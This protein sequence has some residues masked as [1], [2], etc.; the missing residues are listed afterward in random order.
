MPD[1]D[2]FYWRVTQWLLPSFSLIPGRG[3]R[4]GTAW[5]PVDDEHC[6]RYSIGLSPD[7]DMDMARSRRRAHQSASHS[8]SRS[9]TAR[10]ST[11]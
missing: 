10:S 11:R 4:G 7:A 8:S 5:I 1:G 9:R 6:V 3:R 2:S